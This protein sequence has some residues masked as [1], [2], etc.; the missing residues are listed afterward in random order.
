MSAEDR[1]E[2]DR[3]RHA[4]WARYAK[5]TGDTP[6]MPAA[7]VVV[8]R[9]GADGPETLMLRKNSKIAFGGMWVFPGGKVDA[10]DWNEGDEHD[11]GD[12]DN[13]GDLEAN[14]G[15]T[16]QADT[17]AGGRTLRCGSELVTQA[18]PPLALTH[19]RGYSTTSPTSFRE[20]EA[21]PSTQ[22]RI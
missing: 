19:N 12:K 2:T 13:E 17:L 4:A 1:V 20:D 21:P 16:A 15:A 11:E 7:T 6:A 10:E 3:R 22:F 14:A 5:E 9:D 18:T 8:L